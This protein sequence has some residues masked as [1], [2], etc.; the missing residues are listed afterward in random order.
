MR[1]SLPAS[2]TLALEQLKGIEMR[3]GRLTIF[4]V[5]PGGRHTNWKANRPI[6]SKNTYANRS[7]GTC[8]F[9]HRPRATCLV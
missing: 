9:I 3:V 2:A 8:R 1:T 6:L 4:A 7:C 5:R